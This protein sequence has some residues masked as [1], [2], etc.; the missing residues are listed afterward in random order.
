MWLPSTTC[1]IS[2]LCS[3][4]FL[5]QTRRIFSS[6]APLLQQLVFA[7]LT[8]YDE[9]MSRSQIPSYCLFSSPTLS[10][11]CVLLDAPKSR[12]QGKIRCAKD[13]LRGYICRKKENRGRWKSPEVSS[14]YKQVYVSSYCYCKKLLQT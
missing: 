12:C 2:P 6:W 13:L 8:T 1:R 7:P 4:V 3:D 5:A 14:D 9:G 11:T 10:T